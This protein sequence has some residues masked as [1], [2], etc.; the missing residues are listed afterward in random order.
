AVDH[1]LEIRCLNFGSRSILEFDLAAW[2]THLNDALLLNVSFEYLLHNDIIVS[3][4]ELTVCGEL[5]SVFD[6]HTNYNCLAI[7][8]EL[9]NI[10]Q[11]P[12]QVRV[13]YPNIIFFDLG[14][15]SDSAT[16]YCF[17]KSLL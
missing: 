7:F 10:E 6:R 14:R 12:V 17:Y 16:S 5:T 9:L 4:D 2:Q 15:L 11:P 3:S 1:F 13:V 8:R